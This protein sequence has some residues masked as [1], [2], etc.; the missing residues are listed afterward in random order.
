METGMAYRVIGKLDET[1]RLYYEALEIWK[2]EGNLT[3]QANVLN[4]LGVLHH[5][6]GEY[7]KAVIVLDEG[8]LCARRGGF[9]ARLESALL[10][11]LGDVYAEVEDFDLAHQHYQQSQS[12]AEET[13]DRFL[14]NYLSMA[15]AAL[16]LCQQD[17]YKANQLLN[18]VSTSISPQMSQY[19]SGLY[20]LLR[21]QLYLHEA[22]IKQAKELLEEAENCFKKDEHGLES[23]KSQ[24]L[25]AA[26]YS[27]DGNQAEARKKIKE[28]FTSEN[29]ADYAVLIFIRYASNWLEGMLKDKEVGKKL[30]NVF[31][32][33]Q[34]IY[35]EMP[36]IRRRI[37]RLTRTMEAPDAKLKI[38]AFGR[39]KVSI[40]GKTLTLSD[41]QTQSVRD[42]FFYLLMITEPL[43]KE[44]IGLVFWPELEEPAKLKMRFKNEMYRLRRAVGREAILFENNLYSFNRALDFEYDVDAF[45][46]LLFQAKM[47]QDPNLKIEFLKRAVDLVKGQLLEDL[48]AIW[49]WP[50]RERL[51]QEFLQALFELAKLYSKASQEQKA[52]EMYH[53][54][55]QHYPTSEEA[56]ILAMN[57]YMQMNDRVSAIRLYESYSKTIVKE[58]NLPPSPEMEAFYERLLR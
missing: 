18:D 34:R 41:W 17:T 42:L 15:Q 9:S 14:S 50:E 48:D 7:E 51:N 30:N 6:Q 40:G 19:E 45:N 26:A 46:S 33:S 36:E 1:K 28:A 29:R 53:R 57:L 27:L 23:L 10:A 3:W 4:N 37:H 22:E 38:R 56:Y 8:L 11:S 20:Y 43:T 32:Q 58:L 16:S 25:L 39:A 24:I 13:G 35:E 47:T 21:G 5:V 12:I 44:Q 52:L 31:L 49:V 2:K 54:A 55:I